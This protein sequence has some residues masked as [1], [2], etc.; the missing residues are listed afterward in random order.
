ML[1]QWNANTATGKQELELPLTPWMNRADL[2][3]HKRNQIYESINEKFRNRQNEFYGD[4]GQNTG[5]IWKTTGLTDGT[6]E[7]SG[8]LKMVYLDLGQKLFNTWELMHTHKLH[9]ILKTLY[10][11]HVRYSS[12]KKIP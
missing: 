2:I 3:L 8:M 9:G 5:Y 11:I 7:C 10:F 12:I 6:R 1:T 4:K